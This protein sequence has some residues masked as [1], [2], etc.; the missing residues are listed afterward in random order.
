[1]ILEFNKI[2]FLAAIIL[3]IIEALIA[4]FLKDG[5]IRH[6]FGDYLVVILLYCVFKSFIKAKSFYIAILV[7][8]IA[9]IIEFLQLANLLEYLNLQNNTLA[10][11]VLGSTFQISDLIAYTLGIISILVFEYKTMRKKPFNR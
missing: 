3:F 8:G 10:K 7:L 9:F 4:T 5:F 1:M 2:Y 11:L 6:T